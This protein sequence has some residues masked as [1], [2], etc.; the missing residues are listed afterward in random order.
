MPMTTTMSKLLV[1]T[2]AMVAGMAAKQLA[3]FSVANWP[4]WAMNRLWQHRAVMIVMGTND[5]KLTSQPGIVSC[6]TKIK[7][8]VRERIVTSPHPRITHN[9]VRLIDIFSSPFQIDIRQLWRLIGQ[10]WRSWVQSSSNKWEQ[11][12]PWRIIAGVFLGVCH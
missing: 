7:G 10:S 12:P 1:R 6:L 3:T 5:K 2:P 4:V 11:Q 9:S 8:S